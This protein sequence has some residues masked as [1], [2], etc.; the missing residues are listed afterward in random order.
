MIDTSDLQQQIT[1]VE[2]G[3]NYNI[4]RFN[5]L[6]VTNERYVKILKQ[7]LDELDIQKKIYEN[8]DSMKKVSFLF[9]NL[10]YII[11]FF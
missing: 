9:K 3:V 5:D 8:L 6:K 1:I 2:N 10:I 7:K 4:K 11:F